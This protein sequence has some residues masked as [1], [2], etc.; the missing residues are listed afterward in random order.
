MNLRKSIKQP[1]LQIN[2]RD[3]LLECFK[4]ARAE[5]LARIDKRDNLLKLQLYILLIL[6]ALSSGVKIAG[7]ESSHPLSEI[8]RIAIPISIVLA[9]LHSIEDQLIGHL[10]RYIKDLSTLEATLSN[11]KLIIHNSDASAE[12]QIAYIKVTSPLRGFAQAIAFWLVPLAF[13]FSQYIFNHEFSQFPIWAKLDLI[14]QISLST[15]TVWILLYSYRM[16]NTIWEG[17]LK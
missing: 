17:Y 12:L 7:I 9:S 2:R 4:S 3:Y 1:I 10:S 11:S 15:I 5:I 8:W 14:G 13:Y 6:L 16:R